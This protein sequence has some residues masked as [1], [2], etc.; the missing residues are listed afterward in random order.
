[1]LVSYI[2]TAGGYCSVIGTTNN[3]N[4]LHLRAGTPGH[5]VSIK[6]GLPRTA[7]CGDSALSS[8]GDLFRLTVNCGP[9]LMALGGTLYYK[10]EYLD[11]VGPHARLTVSRGADASHIVLRWTARDPTPGSGVAYAHI[12]VKSGATGW[13][14][15]AGSTRTHSIT[16]A[17]QRHRSYKFRLRVRDRVNNWGPWIAAGAR[18]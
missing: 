8:D 11:V 17:V 18:A 16:Y 9:G 14:V 12:E 3:H 2:R 7:S 4:T 5:L 10:K 13:R 6:P 1:M 15:L